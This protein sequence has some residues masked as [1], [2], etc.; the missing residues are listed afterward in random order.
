MAY[1]EVIYRVLLCRHLGQ[2]AQDS[3]PHYIIDPTMLSYRRLHH[4]TPL[5]YVTL[6]LESSYL[7][8]MLKALTGGLGGC[9][10]PL[11]FPLL[12]FHFENGGFLIQLVLSNLQ[13]GA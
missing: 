12:L 8:P 4:S 2:R 13:G 6:I 5:Y 9:S 3:L 7:D 11:A 1:T 10:Q